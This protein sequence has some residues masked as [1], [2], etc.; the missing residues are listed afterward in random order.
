MGEASR[1]KHL[2]ITAVLI[3]VLAPC[4]FSQLYGWFLARETSS[5]LAAVNTCWQLELPTTIDQVLYAA[6]HGGQHC[7]ILTFDESLSDQPWELVSA[8]EARASAAGLMIA[9]Q[10]P[11]RWQPDDASLLP[12]RIMT[13]IQAPARSLHL[14]YF[15]RL[16][17]A[18][19]SSYQHVLYLVEDES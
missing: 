11:A 7:Y 18:G 10:I 5:Y 9:Q 3:L 17:L 8:A 2:L 16:P 19:S 4:A 15:D 1:K 6:D 13:R 12:V 14:I